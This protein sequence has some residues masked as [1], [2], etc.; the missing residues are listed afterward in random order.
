MVIRS[1][2]A[3]QTRGR[4]GVEPGQQVGEVVLLRAPMGA[5][6]TAEVDQRACPVPSSW[7]STSGEPPLGSSTDRTA[8]G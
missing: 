4:D 5:S 2:R 6:P 1:A 3:G 7:S 8:R